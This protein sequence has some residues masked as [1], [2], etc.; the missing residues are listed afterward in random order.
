MYKWIS[1]IILMSSMSAFAGLKQEASLLHKDFRKSVKTDK[2]LKKL[3]RT[4]NNN[5]ENEVQIVEKIESHFGE[6]F[7]FYASS[8][9]RDEYSLLLLKTSF[10]GRGNN[11]IIGV[12]PAIG[13]ARI[14][15]VIA[16]TSDPESGSIGASA[17]AIVGVGITTGVYLGRHGMC[18]RLGAGYGLNVGA[19]VDYAESLND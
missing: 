17:T 5:P 18:V 8:T 10:F 11:L 3:L 1:A 4:L 16:C 7:P 6:S 19:S 14:S 13:Y 9:N 15:E 12:G 2:Q